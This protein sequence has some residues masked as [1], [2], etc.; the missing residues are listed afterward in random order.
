MNIAETYD[1]R[2]VVLVPR[3]IDFPSNLGKQT[4]FSLFDELFQLRELFP[5][6]CHGSLPKKTSRPVCYGRAEAR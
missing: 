2:A 6:K 1:K 4:D 3:A 5:C